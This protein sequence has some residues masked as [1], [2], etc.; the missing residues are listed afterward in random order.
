MY[1]AAAGIKIIQVSCQHVGHALKEAPQ[2][3]RSAEPSSFSSFTDVQSAAGRKVVYLFVCSL[4][5]LLSRCPDHQLTRPRW[6]I[7]LHH[8]SRTCLFT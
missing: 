1:F 7:H 3:W 6:L 8:L 4:F 2:E 5:V